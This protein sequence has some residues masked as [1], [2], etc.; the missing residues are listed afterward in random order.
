VL[1][2]HK[3]IY[4]HLTRA[5]RPTGVLIKAGEQIGISGN[6]GNVYPVPTP[7]NPNAGQHLHFGVKPLNPDN[8]NGTLELSTRNQ[9]LTKE[10]NQ[11][12][13]KEID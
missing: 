9:Y 7:Q 11:C 10:K 4:A 3:T 6:S 5:T 2:A 13:T 1:G 12:S 8:N